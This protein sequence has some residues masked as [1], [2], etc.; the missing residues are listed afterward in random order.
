M[1][2]LRSL[3]RLATR[4]NRGNPPR[5]RVV[6]RLLEVIQ[7]VS[8]FDTRIDTF[9]DKKMVIPNNSVWDGPITNAT[10]SRERRLDM[11][12]DVADGSVPAASLGAATEPGSWKRFV[13][14][15]WAKTPALYAVRRDLI[16]AME[17]KLGAGA[18]R[19][20]A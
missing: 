17:T 13:V 19:R 20:V 2:R 7:Q 9:D 4:V 5:L 14:R 15:F 16:R 1:F 10:A 18:I 12:F 11:E 6:D 8:L 3:R